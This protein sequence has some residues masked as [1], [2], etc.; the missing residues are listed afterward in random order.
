MKSYIY[1]VVSSLTNQLIDFVIITISIWIAYKLYRISGIGES[2]IYQKIE[3]IPVSIFAGLFATF[4]MRLFG[5]YRSNSSILNVREISNTTKCLTVAFLMIMVIMVFGRVAISR[6]V[7]IF[8]Y[9]ISLVLV[10]S[11]KT[12]IYHNKYFSNPLNALNKRI[13]IYGA[14]ELGQAL[15]REF[16]NSPNFG[17]IPVGF[18]DDNPEKIGFSISPSG[19]NTSNGVSILGNRH[20]IKR[21]KETLK[22]DEVSVVSG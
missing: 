9:F 4:V 11:S 12:Y 22:I 20:D 8:S 15:Y 13:L 3:I 17:I 19:F 14:G 6:Y 16:N 21:L 10:I 18:I 2:V 5:V 7:I 1:K